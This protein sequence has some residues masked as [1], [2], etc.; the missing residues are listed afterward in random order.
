M[1]GGLTGV[2]GHGLSNIPAPVSMFYR[3]V[4]GGV[5]VALFALVV[6]RRQAFRRPPISIY[7]IGALFAIHLALF[8]AAVQ[9]TSIAS[10]GLIAYL[11]PVFIAVLAPWLLA[12]RLLRSTIVALAI[13][14]LGTAVIVF[15]DWGGTVRPAG[16]A[17]A[18]GA[19]LSMALMIVAAKRF[20]GGIDPVQLILHETIGAAIV[21]APL[22]FAL[23]GSTFTTANIWS[24]IVLGVVFTGITGILFFWSITRVTATTAGILSYLEPIAS[25]VFAAVLVGQ[26]LTWGIGVGGI[27]I[28]AGGLILVLGQARAEAESATVDTELTPL[29]SEGLDPALPLVAENTEPQVEESQPPAL[30][31][32]PK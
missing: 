31:S 8:F 28:I 11:A 3:M 23:H 12:E 17:L 27:A 26:A 32:A 6:G 7:F 18:L 9:V 16:V 10:A 20:A 30:A 1:A 29:P 22:A 21:L 5:F 25:P 19:A 15:S 2:L 4:V 24:I 13:S 14:L